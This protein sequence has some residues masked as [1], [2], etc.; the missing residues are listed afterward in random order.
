VQTLDMLQQSDFEIQKALTSTTS[1]NTRRYYFG[2]LKLHLNQVGAESYTFLGETLIIIEVF[3]YLL[4]V[5]LRV[6]TTSKLPP[7]LASVK[8]RLGLT[9][10]RFEDANVELDPFEKQHPF[11]TFEF[12]R[13]LVVKHYR[14]MLVTQAAVI[15]CSTDFLGNRVGFLN[16]V[17]EGVSMMT[18]E[19]SVGALVKNVA[20]SLSNSAAK[21]TGTLSEGLG[22]TILDDKHEEG[23]KK[24][25]EDHAGSS[26][27]YLCAELKGFGYGIMGRMTSVI[28]Q[29]YEGASNDGITVRLYKRKCYFLYKAE[30]VQGKEF[31]RCKDCLPA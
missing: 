27:G 20:H 8:Q 28:A 31:V 12:L 4:Q 16:D 2:I 7:H 18:Y 30:N 15:L 14:D 10:I 22:R 1:L 11:E 5:K 29:S 19:G 25:K 6:L 26:G 24:I 17:S 23:R 21:V 9:L 13:A 3:I